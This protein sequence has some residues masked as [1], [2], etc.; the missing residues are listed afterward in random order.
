VTGLPIQLIRAFL[1][2]G[3]AF[4]IYAYSEFP[5]VNSA[6]RKFVSRSYRNLHRTFA[7]VIAL[8]LA[9]GWVVTFYMGR[10]AY[11]EVI[12]N[13]KSHMA[14]LES[15]MSMALTE[16]TRTV[17]ALAFSPWIATA[18]VTGNRAYIDLANTVLD[19]YREVMGVSVC[20][21]LNLRG[22]AIA[23]SNRFMPDSFVGHSYAFRN[24]YQS[25]V[26]GIPAVQ[27]AL[28][29]TSGER[30]YYTSHPVFGPN[31]KIAGVAVIKQSLDWV[32]GKFPKSDPVFF[33]SPEGVIFLSS[34]PETRF[35]GLSPLTAENRQKVI[36]GRQ[37]G[38]GPFPAVLSREP[39]EDEEITFQD[40]SFIV[41]RKALNREG[42]S[43]IYFERTE[44]IRLYRF[45]GT[46]ITFALCMLTLGMSVFFKRSLESTALIAV[47]EGRFQVIF[48]N[49]PGAIFIVDE[50]THRILQ[51]N[52]FLKNWLGYREEELLGMTLEDL[53]V[54]E[55]GAAG[56]NY[57]KKDGSLVDIEETRTQV[58]FQKGE[59][60]L[61]VAHDISDH[62]QMEAI[63]RDQSMRDGLTGLANRRHFDEY[64]EREWKRALREKAPLSIIMCDIDFFKSFNDTYGHQ[65]GDD[66]LQAV[67]RVLEQG[68]RRPLDVAARYG[69][70]E[71]VVVVPGTPLPG[72]LA[73]AESIR[74]GIEALAIP[75]ASS[76][77]APVVTISLGVASVVPAPDSAAADIVSAADQA[78]YRA[79][80]EGRN[81]I[82]T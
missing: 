79:K 36:A 64:L 29:V 23:S 57:R 69:G 14:V 3:I 45:M 7:L 58:P 20:Y 31:G 75:H 24:Y 6:D 73:V 62:K 13:G 74:S 44:L 46:V 8:I 78:L 40:R 52:P 66:C 59:A 37:F 72:A 65:S 51:F 47:S 27:F 80:D 77:A 9:A 28:G 68:L 12:R 26:A 76:S 17:K 22:V 32:E 15:H 55:E 53:R 43:L 82:S 67:A 18:L 34:L 11:R 81:R 42:W 2:I 48:E 56:S 49:A 33:I 19:Q 60:L 70:E 35:A 4:L 10:F 54:T 1:A 50:E 5:L 61:V 63:L 38:P 25:A 16:P 71:F 39:K 41:M 21:L 30:G